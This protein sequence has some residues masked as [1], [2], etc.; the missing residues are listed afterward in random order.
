MN[1]TLLTVFCG[2]LLSVTAFSI[3]IMLPAFE[4]MQGDLGS[5]MEKVQL[6]V[7]VFAIGYAVSQLA[8]G[9]ASDRF[10]RKPVLITGLVIFLAGSVVAATALTIEQVLAGRILQGF[11]GGAGQVIGRAILRDRNAGSQLARAMALAMSIFSF[12]PIFAPL[13]GY[14]LTAAGDWRLIFIA[15]GVFSLSLLTFAVFWLGETNISTDH[16][17]LKPSV[18]LKSLG[19]IVANWQSRTFL[20]IAVFAYCAL[21][22]FV[23]NAPLIYAG[24]FGISGLP[25]AALF[26]STGIGIMLGQLANRKLLARHSILTIMRFASLLLLLVSII[27]TIAVWLGALTALSFTALMFL[28]NTSFLVV[29]SNSASLIIQPHKTIAGMASAML[30]FATLAGSG[31]Y[32]TATLQIFN[33]EIAPWAIGMSITTAI[34]FVS[35]WLVNARRISFDS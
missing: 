19:T 26:A 24:T 29:I 31:I 30:G 6:S 16:K 32:V 11:G 2:L 13:L 28:F 33:G 17:A 18:L 7:P 15:M 12:G 27:I 21:L 14:G 9:P 25:F 20:L 3:D 22:S 35:L 4:N 8:F 23:T 5:S 10:G 1:P 34:T